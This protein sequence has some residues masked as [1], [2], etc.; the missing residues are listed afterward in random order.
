MPDPRIHTVLELIQ[1]LAAGNLQARREQSGKADELDAVI[2]GLN[3]LGEELAATTVSVERY[4][5]VV[6]E[7]RQALYEVKTLTGLLPICAW[8]KKIR[9]DDGYW[10]QIETYVVQHSDAEFTHGICPDCAADMQTNTSK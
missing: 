3:M 2:E 4:Q 9:M 1:A 10:T 8:C 6:R 7:L 5:G